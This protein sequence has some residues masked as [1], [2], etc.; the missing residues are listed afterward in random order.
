MLKRELPLLNHGGDAERLSAEFDYADMIAL[1]GLF[2][3]WAL[4]SP[5]LSPEQRTELI[6]YSA[7]FEALAQWAGEGWRAADPSCEMPAHKILARRARSRSS[8]IKL[9]HD[10]HKACSAM[11]S[12]GGVCKRDAAKHR[13]VGAHGKSSRAELDDTSDLPDG[14]GKPRHR[15]R[16]LH[17]PSRCS[18]R[19]AACRIIVLTSAQSTRRHELSRISERRRIDWGGWLHR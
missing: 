6:G 11:P 4:Y 10:G 19:A 17:R 3:L 14:R 12:H 15:T 13:Y 8:I 1:S 2:R 5:K 16:S 9:E 18:G 7:D